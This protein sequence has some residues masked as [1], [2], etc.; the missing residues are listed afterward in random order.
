[1]DCCIEGRRDEDARPKVR[2]GETDDPLPLTSGTRRD[3][4]LRELRDEIARGSSSSAS[5]LARDGLGSASH[6]FIVSNGLT[7]P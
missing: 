1:M 5:Q 6:L 3:D 4:Q 7:T 2:A